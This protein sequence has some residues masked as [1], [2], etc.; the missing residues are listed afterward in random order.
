[1]FCTLLLLLDVVLGLAQTF[2]DAVL[3]IVF[4]VQGGEGAM[5]KEVQID[6]HDAHA[7]ELEVTAEKSQKYHLKLL[8]NW[9]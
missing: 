5:G 8:L 1:M 3:A 6:R 9:L 4:L 2:L 7:R